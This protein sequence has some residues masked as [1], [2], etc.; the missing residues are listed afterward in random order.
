MPVRIA[1]GGLAEG[2]GS[3]PFC[4]LTLTALRPD[5]PPWT[6]AATPLPTLLQ[7]QRLQRGLTQHQ[8]ARRLGV[9]RRTLLNWELGLTSPTP[10]LWPRLNQLLR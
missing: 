6:R 2:V 1:C 3:R 5:Q 8:L 9:S 7:T 10:S 4:C